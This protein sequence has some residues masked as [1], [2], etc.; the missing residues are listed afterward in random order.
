MTAAEL[1]RIEVS[2]AARRGLQRL[3]SKAATAIIEFITGPLARNPAR[4]RK[5][6]SNELDAYRSA[7]RGD[8]RVVIRVEETERV[9]LVV[10][11]DHRADVYRSRLS[12][13]AT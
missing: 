1:Y 9:V 6:L 5:P 8:Y 4:L 11:I 7:R 3:P 10:R 2:G 13:A 12:F